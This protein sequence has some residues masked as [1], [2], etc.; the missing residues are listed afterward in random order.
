MYLY[1]ENAVT[2]GQLPL[3]DELLAAKPEK[4]ATA[5]NDEFVI[6]AGGGPT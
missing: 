4:L 2:S 1:A 3:F 5:D 6:R